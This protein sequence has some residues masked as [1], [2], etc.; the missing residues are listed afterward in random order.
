MFKQFN[1]EQINTYEFRSH[2]TYTL[3]QSQVLRKQF[4]S[5][6]LDD[7]A[8]N[9][10]N[11]ARINF[12]LSGSDLGSNNE[13]FNVYPTVGNKFNNDKMFFKKFA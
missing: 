7:T 10:Y 6:S 11:F 3:N 12:Y 8:D 1:D 13:K 4:L 2:K 9:Y 5:E